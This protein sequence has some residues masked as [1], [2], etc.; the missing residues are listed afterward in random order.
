MGLTLPQKMAQL[1]GG[2]GWAWGLYLHAVAVEERRWITRAACIR[3]D[4]GRGS[5]RDH[6]RCAVGRLLGLADVS[7]VAGDEI[8]GTA[9]GTGPAL[10]SATWPR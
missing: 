9:P 8:A 10:G 1:V 5:D 4:A 7:G 3:S 6:R 2:N